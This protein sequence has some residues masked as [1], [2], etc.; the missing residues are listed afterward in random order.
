M[1]I[2]YVSSEQMAE[3]DEKAPNE[4]GITISRM[5]ENAAYQIADFIRNNYG[6]DDRIVFY[7][8]KGNNGGDGL[9]AARRLHN[10]GFNVSVELATEDLDGIRLE[11]LDILRNLGMDIEE[12]AEDVEL[13]VDCLIGYNL[14]GNPRPPFDEMI[15]RVNDAEEVISVDVPTGVDADTGERL[16]PSVDADK[17][18]TLALPKTGLKNLYAE[19]WVLVIS[20]RGQLYKDLGINTYNIFESSSRIRLD[21]N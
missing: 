17:I 14:K 8:G 18:L 12:K 9:A 20:I 21:D 15:E 13:A 5:M 4:Y 3:V 7:I 16:N 2:E 6:K 11:E 1:S 19:T 10:W